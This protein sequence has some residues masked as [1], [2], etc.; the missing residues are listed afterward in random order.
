MD[1]KYQIHIRARSKKSN[2]NPVDDFLRTSPVKVASTD[3]D[4]SEGD[5]KF[6]TYSPPN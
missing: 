4:E 3:L 1:P 5:T 2:P 6:Y